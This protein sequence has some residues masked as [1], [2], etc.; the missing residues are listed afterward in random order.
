MLLRSGGLLNL[1]RTAGAPV[2]FS[3]V[4]YLHLESHYAQV[5][6]QRI[7]YVRLG[8]GPHPVLLMPGA[9]G[10]AV[11]DFTPQLEGLSQVLHKQTQFSCQR[12][13]PGIIHIS[14]ICQSFWR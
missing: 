2:S 10:S 8:E 14:Y 3:V 7:H 9:L 12:A 4:R 11:S 1:L 13:C 6:E 5:G